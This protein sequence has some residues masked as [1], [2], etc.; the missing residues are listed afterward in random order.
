MAERK[1]NPVVKQVLELGPT[2]IFFVVYMWIKDESF[3]LGGTT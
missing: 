2:L 1:I 3:V